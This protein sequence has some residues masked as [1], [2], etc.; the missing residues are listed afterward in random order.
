MG[1]GDTGI[2]ER[3]PVVGEL[4][5]LAA[6]VGTRGGRL[7]LVSGEAGIGKTT[8][9]GEVCRQLGSSVAV[10][11]SGCDPLSVPAPLG[12]V[13]EVAAE[14]GIDDDR[15]L[16]DA[17]R[18]ATFA[19]VLR[20]LT[21][22]PIVWVIEDV[23]WADG[24]TADLL[25]FL[26][27]RIERTSALVILTYR[28][29]EV[30]AAPGFRSLLGQLGRSPFA[31]R[32]ELAPLSVEAVSE[33]VGARAGPVVHASTGGNPFF[34]T[35]VL[36]GSP[37]VVPESVSDAV[38]GRIARLGPD[39]RRV[40]EAVSVAPRYLEYDAVEAVAGAAQ[41][42]VRRAAASGVLVADDD[43]LRFRHDLARRAVELSVP[44]P[45]RRR[46]HL[47]L[48]RHLAEVGDVEVARLAHHA[49]RSGDA[50]AIV[51]WCPEAA[52]AAV[53]QVAL[54]EAAEMVRATLR[55]RRRLPTAE[56][57][58]LLA[59]LVGD[60]D[61]STDE[62]LD[63]AD[64]AE[65]SA[66]QA[67]RARAWS[68]VAAHRWGRGDRPGTRRAIDAAVDAAEATGDA[69]LVAE[70]LIRSATYRMLA[71]QATAALATAERAAR[72]VEESEGELAVRSLAVLGCA[73]VLGPRP[74]VGFALLEEAIDGARRCGSVLLELNATLNL[75][76]GAGEVRRYEVAE[77]W[78]ARGVEL[79][80][81]RA[82]DDHLGYVLGWRL[83]IEVERGRWAE[84]ARLAVDERVDELRLQ[85][86]V[87]ATIDGA[88]G[89][90][91]VRRGEPGAVERLSGALDAVGDIE[92]QHRW[93]AH[94][95]LAEAAW[96]EG[97]L[98]DGRALLEGPYA[99]ALGTESP[100]ARGEVGFWY[101][102]CGGE[103]RHEDGPTPFD[104]HVAG[105][106]RAAAEWWTELGCPYEAALA[107][108][109]GELPDRLRALEEL[110][111]LGAGPA[112]AHLRQRLRE[113]GVTSIP[114]GPRPTTR[115]NPA[116]LTAR[117]LEVLGAA[118]EGW[119]NA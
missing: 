41:E 65:R 2:L 57:V 74:D 108:A 11:R 105:E 40:V 56:L 43:G 50:D 75:A 90:L 31:E 19:H 16:A 115:S 68:A 59:L 34:V 78:A 92:L 95:S 36:A 26:G 106:W 35:E 6:G 91:G 39:E 110:D 60:L 27:R 32:I 79:C 70:M 48:L 52:R 119:T 28:S 107:R 87:R 86:F 117:Q 21:E 81:N 10:L 113:S 72:L 116:G 47:D 4:V 101:W 45:V 30:D 18:G 104:L 1:S 64:I 29:D 96:L 73:H 12:P 69:E 14:L 37:D 82:D 114:R 42:V 109:D 5:G 84:A 97:R 111:R 53:R 20:S 98:D 17:D 15:L 61:A 38:L 94:C 85:H 33:L 93:V 77:R 62:A 8:V 13:V 83:R 67:V 24:A 100:W 102:R 63:L 58:E 25:Q 89:R 88:L 118:A 54:A 46:L 49:T 22:A 112:A 23:H 66:D 76:S 71:R 51:R 3:G 55:H 7:V 103:I 80:A 44:V 99:E 9:V